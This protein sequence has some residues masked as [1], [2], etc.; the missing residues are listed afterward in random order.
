MK[1]SRRSSEWKTRF[2]LGLFALLAVLIAVPAQAQLLQGALEGNITDASNA[3][4]IGAEVTI[5]NEQTNAVRSTTTGAAGNYSFPTVAPGTYTLRVSSAGFQAH[6]QTGVSISINNVTRANIALEVGQVTETITVEASAATLQTDRAEVRAEITE[7]ALKNLPVP[8]GRNYQMLFVTL[9]GF[10]PPQ[11]AHSIPSNPSRAVQF[12]VN[13]TSRSNNNTRIDGASSTNIWLPHMTSYLP[14]LEAIETVNVVTNSFDAEQGLAGGAAINVQIKT[15][16]NDIHGSAF[17]YHTNNAMKAYPYVSDRT[18]P[19]PK[20]IFNQF[21]GTFGGPIKKDKLFYFVSYDASRE[22]QFSSKFAD[23]PTAAMKVGDLSAS[24]VPIYDP[25]TGDVDARGRVAFENNQIPLNRIDTGVQKIIDTGSWPNPNK[26]GI[27]T[28]GINENYLGGGGTTFFRD[29]IDSK[30]NWNASEKLSTFVRFSF[31]DFRATNPQIF[32]D[33]GGNFLHPTNSNPGNGYGNTYSGTLSATY[34]MSPNFIV[35][36]Y[37]GYTLQD[38]NVAQQRLDENLGFDFLGVPGLQSDR[39]IDGG[40]PQ[41]NIDGFAVLG[42]TNNFQPYFRNDPGWQYVANGN[43]TKGTHNIRFGTDVYVQHLNHNQPEMGGAIGGSSGGFNF[44]TGT[45]SINQSGSSTN[46]I[47]GLASFLLGTPREAGKIWQFNENGYSTRTRLYSLYLRDRWQMSSKLTLSYGVRWEYYPFPTRAD[48]GLED[49][50]FTNNTMRICGVGEVP[51]D[52]GKSIGKGSF[53]PRIG[54]AY[55]VSDS[56][57]IR[58]GYG[59]TIDPHNYAR[60]L[61]TNYPIMQVQTL[62]F[63]NTRSFSTTLRQ[64]LPVV[65]E[66]DLGNGIIAMPS[67]AV[68]TAAPQDV[69][70]GYIQSWNFTLERKLGQDFIATVGYVATRSTNQLYNLNQNYGMIGGGNASKP[71]NVLFKRTADTNLLGTVG[72]GKYDS[73]QARLERR[74]TGGYQLAMSYTFGKN[75][76]YGGVDSAAGTEVDLPWLYGL[77][78][79]RN[80]LDQT[81]NFQLTSVVELPFGRGRRWAQEGVLSKILGGWQFNGL[82]SRYTGNAFNVTANGDSLNAPGT[83]QRP[84]CVGAPVFLGDRQQWYDRS[85]FVQPTGA[86]LGTCGPGVLTGPGLFNMDLGLFR[87]FQVTERVDFQLRAEMFNMSNT[88]HFNAPNGDRNSSSFM[89]IGSGTRN[90]GREGVDGRMFRIGL[91]IGF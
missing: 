17:E 35:D 67:S 1:K 8:L 10:S 69:P 33:I 70:R 87:K 20:F 75:L 34:V 22:S 65:A 81:H 64:G 62:P 89:I 39:V 79:G 25:F 83:T 18:Q 49:Y 50:D 9:P 60:P 28:L 48:R 40:W 5:T 63:A 76:G 4:V 16:S 12:S 2:S 44:R 13:G 42:M 19:K 66:P 73:L 72:T 91:R 56:F 47:H 80:S 77:N 6:V 58:T 23:V 57:V 68:A 27:G 24:P 85:T 53:A 31:L 82:L 37:F 46:D 90:T 43:W 55:R 3:A 51:T 54:L 41:F 21:G 88:P 7:T 71:L 74:F 61:R 45:T 52:C 86:R 84:D 29:T 78:Y 59:M 26:A 36:A 30:V 38:A 14:G 11:D 15:G 32:G